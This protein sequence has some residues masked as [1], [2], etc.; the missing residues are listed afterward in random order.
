MRKNPNPSE[1]SN[2]IVEQET[3]VQSQEETLEN[4]IHERINTD[5]LTLENAKLKKQ[6]KTLEADIREFQEVI[7]RT[8]EKSGQENS[9]LVKRLEESLQMKLENILESNQLVE[10]TIKEEIQKYSREMEGAARQQI[11][12]NE[13]MF[14]SIKKTTKKYTDLLIADVIRAQRDSKKFWQDERQSNLVLRGYMLLSPALIII[15]ILSRHF[16]WF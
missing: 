5:L 3:V 16:N 1:Y 11:K 15:E 9:E 14:T 10:N 7:H 12:G 8:L 2:N 6:W 13:Q 4:M